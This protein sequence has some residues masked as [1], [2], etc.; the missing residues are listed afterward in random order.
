[1]AE[2][3]TFKQIAET[4]DKR[5]HSV[6]EV[7]GCVLGPG[8]GEG[9]QGLARALAG[10]VQWVVSRWDPELPPGPGRLDCWKGPGCSGNLSWISLRGQESG[11]E[12][13]GHRC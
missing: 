10:S 13:R 12:L 11:S 2:K 9:E 4:S 1:M 8:N 7:E 5:R 3:V 6:E